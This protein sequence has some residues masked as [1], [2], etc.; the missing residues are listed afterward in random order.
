MIRWGCLLAIATA[1]VL[2]SAYSQEWSD[3]G[4]HP[5]SKDERIIWLQK[6]TLARGGMTN[7]APHRS[8]Y[9][10]RASTPEAMA[11]LLQIV[12]GNRGRKLGNEDPYFLPVHT[13][14]KLLG[15]TGRDEAVDA[16]ATYLGHENPRFR[17]FSMHALKVSMNP[18]AVKFIKAAVIDIENGMPAKPELARGS[19]TSLEDLARAHLALSTIG[20][21]EAFG[22]ID[23]SLL[24]LKTR[25][26]D[27]QLLE[28]LIRQNETT[29]DVPQ[30]Q[31]PSPGSSERSAS[32]VNDPPPVPPANKEIANES[33]KALS[34]GENVRSARLPERSE[35]EQ[36]VPL[37]LW[38]VGII[39]GLALVTLVGRG[40]KFPR[41]RR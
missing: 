7:I 3:S 11:Q 29:R 34:S 36:S 27:S 26:G 23:E 18:R 16:I 31:Q 4:S 37:W 24:R 20:G 13:A 30:S 28:K 17:D 38:I 9:K 5:I 19:D 14:L 2:A 21:S 12:N 8:E 39:V 6:F 35:K 33:E 32:N 25:Y 15:A 22:A 1:Q 40:R 41:D 10:R